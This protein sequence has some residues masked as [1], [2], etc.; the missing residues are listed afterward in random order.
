[1]SID[2]PGDG[3][4]FLVP[5]WR[6][7]GESAQHLAS[8]NERD[9]ELRDRNID[10]AIAVYKADPGPFTAGDLLSQAVVKGVWSDHTSPLDDAVRSL[11]DAG[12][13]EAAAVSLV[14]RGEPGSEPTEP[15]LVTPGDW[16]VRVALNRRI[17]LDEPRNAIRW[18]DLALGHLSLGNLASA[19]KAIVVAHALAP[20]NRYVL[21]AI[22]R[23]AS[24]TGELRWARRAISDSNSLDDPWV[25]A[26]EISLAE[27][28]GRPSRN[29]KRARAMAASTSI[30][31][32][33]LSELRG[34]LSVVAMRAGATKDALRDS[35][36][37]LQSPTENSV[38]Q[39][40]WS[41][42]NGLSLSLDDFPDASTILRTYE[43]ESRR[44]ASMGNFGAA[45][46]QSQ[47]WLVDQPIAPEAARF[48]S[49][50]AS[51]MEQL[52]VAIK[53][54]V[55]G[56]NVA[57]S[58]PLLRNNLAYSLVLAGR[59]GEAATELETIDLA[60]AGPLAVATITATKG[61]LAYR[62]GDTRLGSELY[63]AAERQFRLRREPAQAALATILHA[64]E[65]H[66]AGEATA[67]ETLAEASDLASRT[68][69]LLV[70]HW[71]ERVKG[72][73]RAV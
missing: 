24:I 64:Q 7:F 63:A 3:Q 4:R 46:T 30:D 53:A 18:T 21:R 59:L 37:S 42:Q 23:L 71:L 69:D 31:P 26:A 68:D 39:A 11:L 45:L 14:G 13:E 60:S 67:T 25:L 56:L 29:L 49:W 1:M 47:L 57:P 48:V 5:R 61:L 17:L 34:S 36:L 52:D 10:E 16:Q 65:S 50:L 32:T 44:F 58:D 9:L 72:Q 20:S 70:A 28:E 55:Q 35:R 15:E 66:R 19:E 62:A 51:T 2:I 54:A 73:W 8:L 6:T 40:E 38:A 33:H 43:A 22:A 12:L 41:R 27:M